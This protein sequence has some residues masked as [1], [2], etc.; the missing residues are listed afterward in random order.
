LTP[1]SSV[2]R[3]GAVIEEG[4]QI[5]R[6]DK[7]L[8]SRQK[9]TSYQ[10]A[11]GEGETQGVS[12]PRI[13]TKKITGG[14]WHAEKGRLVPRPEGHVPQGEKKKRPDAKMIARQH[15]K[16]ERRDNKTSKLKEMETG[17][18]QEGKDELHRR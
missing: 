9:K 4:V 7:P 8:E 3:E 12:L 11:S 15:T 16:T 6:I 13:E 2:A 17:G 5:S 14:S 1:E 18:T 10:T